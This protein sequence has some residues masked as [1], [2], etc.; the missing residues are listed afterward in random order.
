M[1]WEPEVAGSNP[2]APTGKRGMSIKSDTSVPMRRSGAW[3]VASTLLV[4][5]CLIAVAATYDRLSPTWDEANHI[6]SG[7]ELLEEGNY[8]LSSENPPLARVAVALGPYL[9]GSRL[10]AEGRSR[11]DVE[12]NWFLSWDLGD[13]ILHDHGDV[14]RELALARGGTLVFFVLGAIVLWLWIAPVGGAAAFLAIAMFG[15]HPSILA[16]SGL[17]T[18]DLALAAVFLLLAWRLIR[19]LETPTTPQAMIL[20]AC[21]GL[22]LATKFTS[23]VFVPAL[24]VALVVARIWAGRSDAAPVAETIRTQAWQLVAIILPLALLVLWSSYGFSVGRMAD[25]PSQ[26]TGWTIYG[27]GVG[28][29]RGMLVHVLGEHSIPMPEFL[30][31][32]LMLFSHND[33]GHEAYALGQTSSD[34]FWYFYPLTLAVKTP[35]PMMILFMGALVGYALRPS[36]APWWVAGVLA[37]IPLILL[38]LLGSS[39]NIGS[40]H[41]LAVTALAAVGI[42]ASLPAILATLGE[43]PRR[44]AIG[45]ISVLLVWQAAAAAASFPYFLAYF[46][47]IA[48]H[49]P[50]AFVVDSDLDWAQGIF[51]LEEFCAERGIESL[52][53]SLNGSSDHCRYNLPEIR[54]LPPFTPVRGWIAIS[55]ADYRGI[56][57]VSRINPP[58]GLQSMR[59]LERET[60]FYG[61]LDAHEPVDVLASSI[62]IYHVP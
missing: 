37:A 47:P 48:A 2:V 50:G 16:H 6:A 57:P 3:A 1:L 24:G 8:T 45:A 25:L 32:L 13:R 28:G 34:G 22:A 4:I 40:R 9:D 41:V 46:N 58:C 21:L 27:E 43:G 35:F 7:M 42:G 15:T 23:L 18:T 56:Y 49:D 53:V 62:R 26:V 30:H 19:W 36:R 54:Q 31:G 33:A 10:P 11:E 14:R 51:A 20:G 59:L 60:P 29:W 12:T 44:F 38:A 17:A 5:A 52:Y 61:W 55:E 39:V